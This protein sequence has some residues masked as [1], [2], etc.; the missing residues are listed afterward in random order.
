M[1]HSMI[2]VSLAVSVTVPASA[3]PSATVT[4]PAWIERPMPAV[5]GAI[6]VRPVV[7]DPDALRRLAADPARA[8]WWRERLTRCHALL[9]A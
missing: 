8:A 2:A 7:A 4:W 6:A 9:S 5:D 1:A 3:V